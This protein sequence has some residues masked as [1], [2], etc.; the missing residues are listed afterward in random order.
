MMH[1][2]IGPI[3]IVRDGLKPFSAEK[4]LALL[5]SGQTVTIRYRPP[6]SVTNLLFTSICNPEVRER[7]SVQG[8][9]SVLG[10][11]MCLAL[12]SGRT[13]LL[14]GALRM[15]FGRLE[16]RDDNKMMEYG[17]PAESLV[18]VSVC[19]TEKLW[20]FDVDKR[21]TT[22]FYGPSDT[23]GSFRAFLEF[24][25]KASSDIVICSR[26]TEPELSMFLKD[27]QVRELQL[28]KRVSPLTVQ[29]GEKP[30]TIDVRYDCTVAHLAATLAQQLGVDARRICLSVSGNSLPKSEG[31]VFS[32][33]GTI[34]CDVVQRE[35]E[36]VVE[37]EKICEVPRPDSEGKRRSPS[38]SLSPPGSQPR[39]QHGSVPSGD[40]ELLKELRQHVLPLTVRICD[41]DWTFQ[42]QDD[43]TISTLARLVAEAMHV[44]V[45]RVRLLVGDELLSDPKQVVFSVSGVIRC[46][47]V[48]PP[49]EAVNAALTIKLAS[50]ERIAR[51]GS[52]AFG[53]LYS[54]RDPRNGQIVAI[55]LLRK[56]VL[57]EEGAMLFRREVDILSSVDH[58]TLLCLRGYVPLDSANGDPPAI[59]TD[60][61]SRGSFQGLLDNARGGM[62]PPEWDDVQRLIVL[63]GISVGMMILHNRRII[64]RDLKPA[65]VLLNEKLEPKVADFGLSKFVDIG[66]TMSQSLNRGTPV[67]MAP[68]VL[69]GRPYDFSADVFAYG[70]LLYSAISG[71]RPYEGMTYAAI[72]VLVVK[73]TR[74]LRPEIPPDVDVKWRKLIEACWCHNPRDRPTFQSV[75]Q[76]LGSTEFIDQFGESDRMKFIEYRDRVSPPG[77][78]FSAEQE[79]S[80]TVM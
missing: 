67:F 33:P 75:C 10:M 49:K 78:V 46:E 79:G 2:N 13:T 15:S 61:M 27:L 64:H 65:N 20:V 25:K 21:P 74:G 40:E 29:I 58:E 31:K 23:I 70:I 62:S 18:D 57:S 44:D 55:K 3:D 54:A 1:E 30:C 22:Y 6:E 52:G 37:R 68:E 59:L 38:R 72:A 66:K 17:I 5:R 60:Y 71:Q 50:F 73:I 9:F 8:D 24:T 16:L 36:R 34:K 63:Y 28:I 47:I 77:L 48:E 19:P 42:L 7:C 35:S 51:I 80:C 43:S 11:K 41:D 4:P 56:E 45:R 26:G 53:D 76:R 12:A 39:L 32:F 69:D 14:P